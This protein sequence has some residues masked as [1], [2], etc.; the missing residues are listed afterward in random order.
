MII[1]LGLACLTWYDDFQ[2]HQL[3]ANIMISFIFLAELNAAVSLY[4]FDGEHLDWFHSFLA[5]VSRDAKNVPV[6]MW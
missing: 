5:I 2:L 1:F 4:I 3:L 6:S